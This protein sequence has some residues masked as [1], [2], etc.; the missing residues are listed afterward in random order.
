MEFGIWSN[1]FRPHTSAAETYD[2]DLREIVLA[3]E[4]GFKVAFI[5]DHHGEQ[6]YVDKVDTLPVSEL[7]MCK[8]AGLTRQI[9]MGAAVKVIHLQHPLDVAIQ[10]ATTDHVIGDGRFIFG[11]GSGFPSPAFSLERGLSFEDRQERQQESLEFI[12]KCWASRA[13]FDWDGRHWK[14]KGVVA[15]PSPVNGGTIPIATATETEP[16]IRLAG[17]RGYTLLT[18]HELPQHLKRKTDIYRAAA[19][20]SGRKDSLRNVANARFIYVTD[21]RAKGIDDLKPAVTFELQ[22][23]AA[24]GLLK[25]VNRVNNWDLDENNVT[26]E[27]LVD[28]G[29]YIIGTPDE[30]ADRLAKIYKDSG[31]FGTLL[32]ITGKAWADRER[33]LRSMRLFMEYVA[34]QLR[35]L[36][37]PGDKAEAA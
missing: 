12:L 36:E 35:H 27:Q 21:S 1:G 3:D 17:E 30:V 23:Q 7:L 10:A 16:M 24:R 31:G 9:K 29:W 22:F 2:E 4:L 13:P 28:I 25:L 15:T 37:P 33:R 18:A 6:V 32:M 14:A 34:P 20:A 19:L 11:F 26:L 5:S 8:A